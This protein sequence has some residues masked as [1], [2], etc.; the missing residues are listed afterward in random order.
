MVK[1]KTCNILGQLQVFGIFGSAVANRESVKPL[2]LTTRPFQLVA[3]TLMCIF[4]QCLSCDSVVTDH[5]IA[6]EI[7]A[8]MVLHSCIG[9]T[10]SNFEKGRI[11]GHL[12][13]FEKQFQVHHIV[14]N[15]GEAP[16]I[17]AVVSR[18]DATHNGP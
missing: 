6:A 5:M 12:S 17:L 10:Y 14:D 1:G 18:P 7:R 4:L 15:N 8:K 11:S 16:F 3:I 9:M 13:R 2:R